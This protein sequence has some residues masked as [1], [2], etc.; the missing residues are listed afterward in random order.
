LKE[1]L[2]RFT[3][4]RIVVGNQVFHVGGVFNAPWFGGKAISILLFR[5]FLQGEYNHALQ[6]RRN[7][8]SI[9]PLAEN[10]D[11]TI[12]RTIFSIKCSTDGG[13]WSERPVAG[14]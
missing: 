4:K 10:P 14:W 5:I 9:E 11:S 7:W 8:A 3:D 12:G 1:C 6:N 13:V 2:H